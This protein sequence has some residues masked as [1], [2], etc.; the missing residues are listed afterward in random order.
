MATNTQQDAIV[1]QNQSN[2]VRQLLKDKGM[3]GLVSTFELAIYVQLWADF[4]QEG[5]TPE[6]KKRFKSF[7]L[8]M[9]DRIHKAKM[10]VDGIILD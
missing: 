6:I 7:D 3:I 5:L 10:E 2:N 4:C 8:I 9:Q 1:R